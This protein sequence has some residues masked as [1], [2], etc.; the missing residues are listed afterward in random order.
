MY[1]FGTVQLFNT[2]LAFNT[3]ASVGCDLYSTDM[4]SA[5]SILSNVSFS[6]SDDNCVTSMIQ[7][8]APITILCPLGWWISP[9]PLNLP[10]TNF[11]GCPTRYA[12]HSRAVLFI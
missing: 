11:T 7:I 9:T 2:I 12:A 5:D 1:V 4:S 8:D 10:P 6:Q 3:A